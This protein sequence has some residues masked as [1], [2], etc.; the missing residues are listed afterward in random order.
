MPDAKEGWYIFVLRVDVGAKLDQ[1]V[2]QRFEPGHDREHQ[3]SHALLS[4]N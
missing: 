1:L 2:A 3:D 4:T